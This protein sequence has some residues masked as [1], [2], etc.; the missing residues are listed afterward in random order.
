[1]PR[2]DFNVAY[3]FGFSAAVC[4][5]CAIFVAGA[6]VS[7]AERQEI[8]AALA[9]QRNVL[10]AAG[11]VE[12]GESYEKDE[13]QRRFAA[14]EPLVV[15]RSDGTVVEDIDPATFDQQA[16]KKD[17]ETSEAAPDNDAGISRLP[18]YGLVYLVRDEAG[19]VEKLVLP[20]EGYG[21]WS[22]LYGFLALEAD[23]R[24]I[25]GLTFYQHGETPGLGGEVDNQLWKNL[26][27]GRKAFDED[28]Q[29]RIEVIKGSA[30]PA[31]EAPYLV[32]GLSGATIT[33]RG[34]MHLVR[35]WIGP[36]G[37]GPF[38]ERYREGLEGAASPADDSTD[39]TD[40]ARRAA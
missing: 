4:G 32:D 10:E 19:E 37:F 25:A 11:L 14:V 31:E 23:A 16:T 8:N 18:D 40:T 12:P 9:K 15:R 3:V 27:R 38:L 17:A 28:W 26:W 33:S 1:M 20:V 29:P 7:L 5:V 24:T 22:T 35:F 21:L 39:S 36:E 30:P 34:V 2:R 6:A 13:I